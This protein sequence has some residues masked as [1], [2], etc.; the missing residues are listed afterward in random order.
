[1][2]HTS[3]FKYIADLVKKEAGITLDTGKEYLVESRVDPVAR[4]LGF[5][6]IASFVLHLQ[7]SIDNTQRRQVVESLTTHETSFFRDVEPFEALRA[8]IIPAIIER[9][10][11]AKEISIWCGAASSGQEPYS[12]CMLIREHFPMLSSWKIR[13]IATDISTSILAK[14]KAGIF[15]QIEV[16]RGLPVRLLA[17]YFKKAEQNWIIEPEIREM[18]TFSELN[19]LHS[20]SSIPPCDLVMLRNVLI[21][22]DIETKRQILTKVSNILRPECCLFLGTAETTLNL[23]DYYERVSFAKTSCYRKK[24]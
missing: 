16:N 10:R 15:N 24:A 3:D 20:Y 7:R 18:V 23:S 5:Q 14:A 6:D 22:F 17:K 21:Y 11:E 4:T 9:Q 1:M 19:L 8:E 2:L 13:F 12:L